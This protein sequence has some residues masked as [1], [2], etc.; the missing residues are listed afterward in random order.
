M[1][2]TRE[3]LARF[4]CRYGLYRLQANA[5]SDC[6]YVNRALAVLLA[7]SVLI[8]QVFNIP[9]ELCEKSP[10]RFLIR[11]ERIALAGVD[12]PVVGK[13]EDEQHLLEQKECRKKTCPLNTPFL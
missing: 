4:A 2:T 9:P 13:S 6:L 11:F 12:A 7:Q 5:D 8:I 1:M 3:E 10:L